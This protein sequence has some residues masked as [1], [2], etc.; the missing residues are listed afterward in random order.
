MYQ[1]P[2]TRRNVRMCTAAHTP[3]VVLHGVSV[4]PEPTRYITQ[5]LISVT[6]DACY[7][8]PGIKYYII[9]VV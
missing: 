2:G 3:W 5:P 9:G 6:I 8:V 1:V 4:N 7:Q